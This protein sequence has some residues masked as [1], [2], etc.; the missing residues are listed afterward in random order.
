VQ[1]HPPQ[2]LVRV[3]VADAGHGRLVEQRPLELGAA[4]A[5]RG[6]GV[7]EGE[8]GVHRV[9]G[10]VGDRR[11]EQAT[12]RCIRQSA[13]RGGDEGVR[14]QPAERAL[15]DEPQLGS[16]VGK[17]DPDPQVLLVGPTR[18]GDEHLTAHPEVREHRVAAGPR[19]SESGV[20][21]TQRSESGVRCIRVRVPQLEPE[22][23]PP[24]PR[25]G[26]HAPGQACREVVATLEVPAHGAGVRHLD[27]RD[28]AADDVV[29]QASPDDLDLG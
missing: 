23:L 10:D 25:R 8:G 20:R 12:A 11:G 5:D 9:A 13:R 27:A 22:V 14:G 7:V 17:H 19:C 24:P 1:L 18:D 15:V 21:C 2:R 6:D 16:L 29:G 4:A 26:D 28:R 3:D